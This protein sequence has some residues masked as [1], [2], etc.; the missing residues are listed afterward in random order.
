MDKET[1]IPR[2]VDISSTD[3]RKVAEKKE[4]REE[5]RGERGTRDFSLI[6]YIDGKLCR[7]G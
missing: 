5:S 7:S 2:E 4:K 1:E 3:T 6:F